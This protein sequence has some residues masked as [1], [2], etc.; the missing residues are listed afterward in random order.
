MQ[1]N[2]HR[3]KSPYT[4]EQARAMLEKAATNYE[5]AWGDKLA[6]KAD[7]LDTYRATKSLQDAALQ[8]TWAVRDA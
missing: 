1:P 3:I 5:R 4:P 6:G 7:D 2:S 8:F